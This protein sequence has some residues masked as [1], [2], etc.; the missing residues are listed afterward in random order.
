MTWVGVLVRRSVAAGTVVVLLLAGVVL[1][2]CSG[3]NRSAAA[4]CHVWDTQA[5]PLHNRYQ[6]DATGKFSLQE[7]ADLIAVPQTLANL[8]GNLAAVAPE[9]IETDFSEL[10]HAFQN[11]V[12]NA[13]Q[14]VTNPIGALSSG[15]VSGLESLGPYDRVNSYLSNNCGPAAEGK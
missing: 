15:L 4:V 2:S 11:E 14:A 3:S 9:P 7:L 13:G 6:S 1:A 12:N 10:Q 5:V 8:M